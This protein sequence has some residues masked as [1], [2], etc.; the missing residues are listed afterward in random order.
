MDYE[1]LLENTV[2]S[3]C[4]RG[5]MLK[6]YTHLLS[7]QAPSLSVRILKAIGS[8]GQDRREMACWAGIRQPHKIASGVGGD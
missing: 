5:R 4:R 7:P 1:C 8:A 2:K 6:A 3:G